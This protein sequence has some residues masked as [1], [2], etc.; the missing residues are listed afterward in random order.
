MTTWT[1]SYVVK[2]RVDGERSE[3]VA[4]YL[5][6]KP[7]AWLHRNTS[8]L[9]KKLFPWQGTFDF[10]TNT[11]EGP[12]SKIETR[13][14]RSFTF[15]VYR[16]SP[17][18]GPVPA[19]VI[20]IDLDSFRWRHVRY[21]AT[22]L[23][24][25]ARSLDTARGAIDRI[26]V[27]PSDGRFRETKFLG[28]GE[29][30][31]EGRP[32]VRFRYEFNHAEPRLNEWKRVFDAFFECGADGIVR[33][34]WRY[35]AGTSLRTKIYDAVDGRRGDDASTSSERHARTV[36]DARIET[37]TSETCGAFDFV[38]SRDGR[39]SEIV[40]RSAEWERTETTSHAYFMQ[41]TMETCKI[42]DVVERRY[43]RVGDRYVRWPLAVAKQD[44]FS[45]PAPAIVFGA[46]GE[47]AMDVRSDDGL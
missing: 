27:M 28:V 3:M 38:I 32:I 20:W 7:D 35:E 1:P 16:L 18:F 47:L 42:S 2:L 36:V 39:P 25:F 34:I 45:E 21:G 33:E 5:R 29:T 13:S 41:N 8:S 6:L 9:L 15:G 11:F 12:D 23:V 43:R 24:G 30:N 10:K 4:K 37:C 31:F 40:V 19:Y 17:A 14:F 44:G 22:V 46:N 26:F